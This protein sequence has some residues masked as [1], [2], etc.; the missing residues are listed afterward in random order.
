MSTLNTCTSN[1]RPLLPDNGDMLFETD[2][3]TLILYYD[4]WRTYG[5]TSVFRREAQGINVSV[6]Y[7]YDNRAQ[8]ASTG[9]LFVIESLDDS[10]LMIR[11]VDSN[12]V[13]RFHDESFV[14]LLSTFP[15]TTQ[16][17]I[18]TVNQSDNRLDSLSANLTQDIYITNAHVAIPQGVNDNMDVLIGPVSYTHADTRQDDL[19]DTYYS[20]TCASELFVGVADDTYHE[21]TYSGLMSAKEPD[22]NPL[23]SNMSFNLAGSSNALSA[24]TLKVS[25]TVI[26]NHM[27]DFTLSI[28]FKMY[29]TPRVTHSSDNDLRHILNASH[30]NYIAV[31]GNNTT[32]YRI[33]GSS[34]L[35]GVTSPPDSVKLDTWHNITMIN[36]TS[37]TPKLSAF[38]DGSR[39]D[40]DISRSDTTTWTYIGGGHDTNSLG[41]NLHGAVHSIRYWNKGLSAI[42]DFTEIT[43]TTNYRD[44]AVL[45]I[46]PGSVIFGPIATHDKTSYNF[47]SRNNIGGS[48]F[49]FTMTN[50]TLS[51]TTVKLTASNPSPVIVNDSPTK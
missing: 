35:N 38:L 28:W 2:T 27:E 26:A 8:Q 7:Q 31:S 37:Q 29:D 41:E 42:D 18:I 13:Y 30:N 4:G 19:G 46:T 1:T 15:A 24:R 50:I 32:G 11:D 51:E 48:L 44:D 20:T 17:D 34:H 16:R 36:N 25:P 9:D 3:Q 22:Y 14:P 43:T 21:N 5:A 45:D 33:Y 23:Y 49:N 10:I 40:G 39:I 12:T 6:Q 47:Q